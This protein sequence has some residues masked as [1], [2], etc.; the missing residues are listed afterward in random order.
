MPSWRAFWVIMRAK[1]ASSPPSA[2]A[3]TTAASLADRVTKP[4]M[5]SRTVTEPPG[6]MPILVGGALAALVDTGKASPSDRRPES[7]A[8]EGE[9]E[10]HQLGERRRMAQLVRLIGRQARGPW[11][12][13]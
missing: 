2:S 4:M 7:S 10:R 3:S 12:R 1:L 11:S 5:A 9:I 13:R 6:G 8:A